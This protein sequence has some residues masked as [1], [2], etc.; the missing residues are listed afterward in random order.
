MPLHGIASCRSRSTKRRPRRSRRHRVV[1][2]PTGWRIEGIPLSSVA[3]M[4]EA[5]GDTRGD[6]AVRVFA[7][8]AHGGPAHRLQPP[9][10][11][12]DIE[13]LRRLA[14]A[15]T[16]A[17]NQQLMEAQDPRGGAAPLQAPG[18]FPKPFA[19]WGHC[20]VLRRSSGEDAPS[21]AIDASSPQTLSARGHSLDD[22]DE[23]EHQHDSCTNALP[24][25]ERER[26]PLQCWLRGTGAGNQ[27]RAM[28]TTPIPGTEMSDHNPSIHRT[29]T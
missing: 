20:S 15:P 1:V 17:Q 24:R 7:Y 12:L 10:F 22:A 8:P 2:S 23:A 3:Q 28:T 6:R 21:S 11:G 14:R 13:E 4:C 19:V 16:H 26:Q 5:Q 25:R 9:G 18:N 29:T 27:A